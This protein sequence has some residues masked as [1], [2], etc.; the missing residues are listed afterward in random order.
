MRKDQNTNHSILFS[1]CRST[2]CSY[3]RVHIVG[4]SSRLSF[5]QEEP[6]DLPSLGAWAASTVLA[7]TFVPGQSG[8]GVNAQVAAAVVG[9]QRLGTAGTGKSPTTCGTERKQKERNYLRRIKVMVMDTLNWLNGWVSE[10]SSSDLPTT[11]DHQ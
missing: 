9:D 11:F 8:D 2:L 10:Y 7:A 3:G 5:A 6:V 1:L 4:S